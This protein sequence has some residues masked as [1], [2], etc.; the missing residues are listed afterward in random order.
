MEIGLG[1]SRPVTDK[2]TVGGRVKALLG[3]GKG[4]MKVNNFNL[5]VDYNQ[6][7]ANLSQDQIYQRIAN[8]DLREDTPLG[9]VKY[10]ADAQVSTTVKGGGLKYNQEGNIS[11]FDFK[12]EDAGVAGLG[13]GIDLGASY[14]VLDH[15][16]VSAAVLDLGYINCDR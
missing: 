12:A 4:Q 16:T 2:L 10:T 6:E 13:F 9:T 15:F 8:G 1:Y 3:V 11:G 5:N 14:K 7:F